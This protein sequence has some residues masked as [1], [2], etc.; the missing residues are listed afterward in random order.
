M[1]I[2]HSQ[3]LICSYVILKIEVDPTPKTECNPLLC[4][5]SDQ[6]QAMV[7]NQEEK[8]QTGLNIQKS[9]PC[10]QVLQRR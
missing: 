3:V 10:Q 1:C 8:I 7:K 6:W 2:K 4:I 9:L 5:F